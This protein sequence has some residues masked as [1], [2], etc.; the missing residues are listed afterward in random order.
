M[1]K[2]II[3]SLV[4]IY[5]LFSFEIRNNNKNVYLR[6]WP[7]EKISYMLI[8]YKLK[9]IYKDFNPDN[10]KQMINFSKE[11]I[12]FVCKNKIYKAEMKSNEATVQL[13]VPEYKYT[14]SDSFDLSIYGEDYKYADTIRYSILDDEQE[15]LSW[16]FRILNHEEIFIPPNQIDLITNILKNNPNARFV[17]TE[18]IFS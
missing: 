11:K 12:L 14:I 10:K 13:L 16:Y 4:I 8:P 17:I 9:K 1:K 7:G 3:I 2:K 18:C 15:I 6:I 5:V